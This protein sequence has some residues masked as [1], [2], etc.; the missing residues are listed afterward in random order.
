MFLWL[1]VHFA[2]LLSKSAAPIYT[3]VSKI[4]VYEFS[5]YL[6]QH[7]YILENRPLPRFVGENWAS[8]MLEFAFIYFFFR[9]FS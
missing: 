2:K 8:L 5:V 1:L 6:C 4:R 7:Y 3:A 9:F